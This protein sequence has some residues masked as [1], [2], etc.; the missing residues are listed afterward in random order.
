MLWSLSVEAVL[1]YP[2]IN[3]MTI[4]ST[5]RGR[6]GPAGRVGMDATSLRASSTHALRGRF[7]RRSEISAMGDWLRWV[8]AT[9]CFGCEFLVP[10]TAS[11]DLGNCVCLGPT[12]TLGVQIAVL[13]FA[14]VVI[15]TFG[16][17]VTTGSGV[18]GGIS[19]DSLE[20]TVPTNN[21]M[22]TRAQDLLLSGRFCTFRLWKGRAGCAA[23]LIGHGRCP[24]SKRRLGLFPFHAAPVIGRV[25]PSTAAALKLLFRGR[26]LP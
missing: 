21:A 17:G 15:S 14:L 8:G 25:V 18:G 20:N 7:S 10:F 5:A 9:I 24:L 2:A 23:L 1:P 4:L 3:R 12:A 13:P 19:S 22:P 16:V 26:A 6:A 11:S